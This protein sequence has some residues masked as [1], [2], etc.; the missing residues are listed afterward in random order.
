MKKNNKI[1]IERK[2]EPHYDGRELLCFV[3]R[4]NDFLEVFKDVVKN[5]PDRIALCFHEK[6]I[7][8]KQLDELSD[9]FA[10]GLLESGLKETNILVINLS[11]SIEFVVALFASFKIRLIAM[12]VG[13]RHKRE[14]L[15][16][17]YEDAGVH[18]V[19]FDKETEKEQPFDD[20]QNSVRF[21]TTFAETKIN[22]L[23]FNELLQRGAKEKIN[24]KKINEEEPAILLYTSGTTGRPKGAILTHLG[25]V[26]SFLHF[27]MELGLKD[28]EITILAVPASHVTGLVAQILTLI[29]CAG[30]IVIMEHFEVQNFALLAKKHELTYSILVPAMYA[31]LL[32]RNALVAKDLPTWKIGAFGGAP[33]PDAV[34]KELASKLPLLSLNNAY[35][36]TETTS[37]TTIIPIDCD[38]PGDS[39]GLIVPC[40]EIKIVNENNRDVK[41]GETGELWIKGPMVVPGYWKNVKA[42]KDSFDKGYWKSGDIA[43]QDENGF[44]RIHDRKKD[45]I[46]RGG[47]KIFSAEIE[48]LMMLM[49]E[50][51]EAALVP[52]PCPILGERS[53]AFVFSLSTAIDPNKIRLQLSRKVADYKVPDKI[54]IT[55]EPLPRNVN[56]KITKAPLR[57]MANKEI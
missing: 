12:P 56:G 39:V 31:L 13:N 48:N 8:Y 3:N 57:D 9:N 36:A 7:T 1:S 51:Q 2:I 21:I 44:I 5:Y 34:R 38:D 25:L 35:G 18:A 24:L 29:G 32:H 41:Q 4:P 46:N 17:L 22:C 42:T 14:E 27:Q 30:K 45:M 43:S 10:G 11:N 54:T 50:V 40:G 19:I 52:Y 20:Y 28:G 49:D 15:T 47:Y 16:S 26:H 55:Q 33:M 53:H 23:K 37:P 6:I